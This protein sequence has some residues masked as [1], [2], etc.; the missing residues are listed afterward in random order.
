M[1]STSRP[2]GGWTRYLRTL[3]HGKV[4]W[5]IGFALAVAILLNPIFSPPFLVVLGRTMFV[6]LVLLLAFTAAGNWPQKLLPRWLMQTLAVAL[7]APVATLGVYLVATGGDVLAILQHP[8]RVSGFIWISGSAL[9][10]GLVL[11]LGA[12]V[13]E[14]DAQ[15]R[16]LQLQFELDRA[17]L[18]KQ[19]VD[20]RLALLTAQIEPHFLFNTL[21]N[22]QALVETGSPR[23]AEVLKSLIAYLRAA[24]PKLH[25]SGASGGMPAL[26]N[27]V[28]LVRSYLELMHLRMPDRLQFSVEVPPE[29]L[30]L[31]FPP[32]ALLTLVENAVRHG[33]DP[34]EE[35][36]RI[37]VGGRQE[38]DG[39][40]RLWVA[41]TGVGL[42]DNA[43]PGTG[44]ANLRARLASVF[45]AAA[46]LELSEQPPHGV[47]AEIVLP[48]PEES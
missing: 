2:A 45:G 42:A 33:I 8:G 4:G 3:N 5:T 11:A 46:R 31:R 23:A 26:V 6:A 40:L 13:R 36:G 7:A 25:E 10:I 19:A 9:I 44:L 20:A 16:S 24:L 18:E 35:G 43:A 48:K 22:V 29:L 41:D 17:Q 12:Q 34:G 15:A 28:T 32:M 1:P 38:A 21:A 37:E 47:R 39:S 14:R 27:E 30:S